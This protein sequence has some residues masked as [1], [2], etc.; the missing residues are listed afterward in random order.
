MG[1]DAIVVRHKSAG[2]PWQLARRHGS[3]R[4]SST[5]ATAGTSTRRRR[6]STATRSASAAAVAG[7][8]AHR[9]RRRHQAQPRRP[10][11]RPRV[12][13]PRR[14]GHAGRPADAAAAVARRLAGRGEPRPRRGAAQ[15]RCRL[16]AAHAARAHDRGAGAEPARVHGPLWPHPPTV[17]DLLA[18]RRAGHAPGP[19]EPRRRDR[20]RG[21]RRSPARVITQQVTNGVAVRMAVLFLLL[22]S[23]GRPLPP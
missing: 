14:R 11:R 17:R 20:G 19:D 18:E 1:V 6:C 2:V 23:G 12:H 9:H 10:L 15:G 8:A 21:R 4:R 3:T 13:R 22:G 7:R 5:P 16:P